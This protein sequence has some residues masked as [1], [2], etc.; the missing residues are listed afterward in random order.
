MIV[1][2]KAKTNADKKLRDAVRLGLMRGKLTSGGNAYSLHTLIFDKRSFPKREDVAGWI[3]THGHLGV[4]QGAIA[5]KPGEWHIRQGSPDSTGLEDS[6]LRCDVGV[7]AIIG[8]PRALEKGIPSSGRG[9][10]I[11]FTLRPETHMPQFPDWQNLYFS[12]EASKRQDKEAEMSLT[13]RKQTYRDMNF[14]GIHGK[15]DDKPTLKYLSKEIPL[16]YLT[17]NQLKQN[18]KRIITGS[19]LGYDE[20]QGRTKKSKR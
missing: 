9:Q 14:M 20:V 16:H 8:M 3:R 7:Q 5:S 10:H 4:K 11:G 15:S 19:S 2:E 6:R 1:G 12:P 18:Q 17:V 13:R